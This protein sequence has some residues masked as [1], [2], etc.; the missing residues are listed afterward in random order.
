MMTKSSTYAGEMLTLI[1]LAKLF[2]R[3][4]VACLKSKTK[5]TATSVI[6]LQMFFVTKVVNAEISLFGP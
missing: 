1:L 3:I 6:V 5:K 4:R 2:A